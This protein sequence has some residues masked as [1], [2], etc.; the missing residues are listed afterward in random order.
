[1]AARTRPYLV[2]TRVTGKERGWI[3]AQARAEGV[4]VSEL[5]HRIIVPEIQR[6]LSRDL[7]QRDEERH[8]R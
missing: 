5:L 4:T 8:A 2:A 1:M 6:R 3:D 7:A